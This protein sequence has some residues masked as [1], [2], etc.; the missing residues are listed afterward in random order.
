[1]KL[2]I[3]GQIK[4]SKTEIEC[5]KDHIHLLVSYPPKQS[6]TNIVT[7]LKECSTFHIWLDPHCEIVYKAIFGKVRT[8]WSLGYFAASTGQASLATV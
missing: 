2:A 8:F 1:M 3:S 7:K 6:V 4:I 5:V